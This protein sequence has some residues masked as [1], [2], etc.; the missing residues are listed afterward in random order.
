MPTPQEHCWRSVTDLELLDAPPT[1][2][3]VLLQML[4]GAEI[5]WNERKDELELK[6]AWFKAD[7]TL[8]VCTYREVRDTCLDQSEVTMFTQESGR[9]TTSGETEITVCARP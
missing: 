4:D 5:A 1:H 3:A 7:E 6:E 9:W 2:R 8:K